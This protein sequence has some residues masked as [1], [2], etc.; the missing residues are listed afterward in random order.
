[1]KYYL[2][3]NL[4][5]IYET[6]KFSDISEQEFNFIVCIVQIRYFYGNYHFINKFLTIITV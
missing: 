5:F 3:E 1:M 2:K 6:L 4:E